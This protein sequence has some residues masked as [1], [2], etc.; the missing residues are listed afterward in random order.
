MSTLSMLGGKREKPDVHRML[1]LLFRT[2]P[3]VQ[4]AF[5]LRACFREIS[6]VL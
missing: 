4:L 1:E 2:T 6:S 3:V 5:D